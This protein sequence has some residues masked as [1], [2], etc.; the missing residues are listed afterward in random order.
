MN[1]AKASS[2]RSPAPQEADFFVM[3]FDPSETRGKP[4]SQNRN[5]DC[6]IQLVALLKKLV[7]VPRPLL[8]D[9]KGIG[10]QAPRTG[11]TST[12]ISREGSRLVVWKRP[13]SEWRLPSP[14]IGGSQRNS[15]L[16]TAPFRDPLL[17]ESQSGDKTGQE[18]AKTF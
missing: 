3:G 7:V 15:R 2:E 13:P 8:P 16:K 5:L 9:K 17:N 1:R 11:R 18:F 6:A 10:L 14:D 12:T 4:G